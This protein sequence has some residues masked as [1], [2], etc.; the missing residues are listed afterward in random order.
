MKPK[1]AV[2]G[3]KG[4]PAFGGA[5]AVGENII[6][7]LKDQ[8]DFTVYSI[9][10]HTNLK[11]GTVN[12]YKQI[13]FKKIPFKKLNTLYYYILSAFHAILF[14]KYNLIHL[15]HRDASFILPL[16]RLRYK[17]V[18]TTH[19]MVLTKKWSKYSSLFNFQDKLFLKM[20]NVITCVS[21]KDQ[22]FVENII[23]NKNISYIPNGVNFFSDILPPHKKYK[24]CFAAGRIVPDKG[25][26]TLLEA[27]IKINFKDSVLIIGDLNQIS[28][29]KNELLELSKSLPNITFTGLITDKS[30][31]YKYISQSE[32]FVYPSVIESMSMMLLEVAS[33][34]TPIICC[35]IRE[36]KDIFENRD[37]LFFQPENTNDLSDKINSA[38]LNSNKMNILAENAFQKVKKDHSWN[39]ISKQY[40]GIYDSYLNM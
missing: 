6:E 22:E 10:S 20:A 29:Y 18:L 28:S 5:A 32:I 19:G 13:V 17:V 39:D 40:Q 24:I 8:Y 12:G 14:K 34:K 7:Q 38:L 36:N 11:T 33:L 2:I 15:H 23:N 3:L 1:I 35:D 21:K 4:L 27:L 30:S 37:V 9:S 25:C 16:L 26:H 31:L